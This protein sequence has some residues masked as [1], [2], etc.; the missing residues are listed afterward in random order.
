MT[1]FGASSLDQGGTALRAEVR[2]VNHRHLQIKVRLPVE[3]GFLEPDVE[4]LVKK[5]IDRGAVSVTVLIGGSAGAARSTIDV[6][7]AAR[8]HKELKKLAKQLKIDPEISIATLCSLPGVIGGDGEGRDLDREAKRLLRV[9][10]AALAHLTEMRETEGLALAED[11]AKHVRSVRQVTVRIA[12]RT[13]EVVRAHQKNLE[14]RVEELL[15]G[16]FQ[17][18]PADLAREVALLAD[19]LDVSEELARLE[20]HVVQMDALLGKSGPVG[21]RLDFL[22]QEMLREVNT[23]GSK[24]N[25]APV[26]HAV[27]ELKGFIERLREQVQ[28]IE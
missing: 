21:R 5:R 19:K 16:R 14:R 8:F 7:A 22:V 15:A 26:A 28:N 18:Q 25:D 20:S 9:V 13:P 4:A 1:G 17:L 10:S 6:E 3:F 2:S 24:C 12:A 27:I 23:I 11:L